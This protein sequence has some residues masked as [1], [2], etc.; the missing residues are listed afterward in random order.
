MKGFTPE[1]HKRR[2]QLMRSGIALQFWDLARIQSLGE[3][4]P[5]EPLVLQSSGGLRL[6]D[7]QTEAIE[8]ILERYT[9]RS[10]NN[11]LV[12]LATGLG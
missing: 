1:A 3:A 7:Y 6:R 5:K 9:D 8:R 11:A 12:V 10:S 2:E 4:L